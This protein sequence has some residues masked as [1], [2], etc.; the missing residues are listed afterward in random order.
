M[1]TLYIYTPIRYHFLLSLLMYCKCES[2]CTYPSLIPRPPSP[3]FPSHTL[4]QPM[5]SC[6]VAWECDCDLCF[7][8]N[9][10]K[11]GREAKLMW[12]WL[13]LML[14]SPSH[15]ILQTIFGNWVGTEVRWESQDE[16]MTQLVGEG[17]SL[18][19]RLRPSGRER[20]ESQDESTTQLVGEGGGLRTR[21]RPSW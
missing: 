4:P 18:R 2:I 5:G 13:Q 15:A 21:L 11:S 19:M 1:H 6:S 20:W 8:Q 9:E 7:Y 10:P 14:N 3:K 16:S 12:N 17:G